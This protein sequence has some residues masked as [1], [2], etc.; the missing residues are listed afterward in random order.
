MSPG[1]QESLNAKP[2]NDN[3]L[4]AQSLLGSGPCQGPG[5]RTG[6]CDGGARHGVGGT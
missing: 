4:R 1:R 5:I 3:T 6:E 2:N